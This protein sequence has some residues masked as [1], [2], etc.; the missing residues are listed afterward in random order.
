M[1]FD[2]A[3]FEWSRVLKL[4]VGQEVEQEKRRWWWSKRGRDNEQE[5][6]EVREVFL[7]DDHTLTN[8]PTIEL[9]R[10]TSL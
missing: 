1:F 2:R 3:Y 7:G 8:P 9:A 10:R 5:M 4:E 6:C